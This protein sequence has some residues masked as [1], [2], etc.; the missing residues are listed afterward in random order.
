M[1]QIEAGYEPERLGRYFGKY[2]GTV[3]DNQDP[4][5]IGRIRASVPGLLGDDVECGWA[6]P[7]LPYAGPGVGSFL[8]PPVGSGVW[9]EFEAGDLDSPIWSGCWWAESEAPGDGSGE[10]ATPEIKLIRSGS[11]LILS[12]NDGESSAFLGDEGGYNALKIEATGKKSTLSAGGSVVIQAPQIELVKDA[13]HALV[14]GD[15]LMQFL[16][17]IVLAFNS[18]IHIGQM[19]ASIPVTPMAPSA[20]MTPPKPTMLS[21][22]VKTG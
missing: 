12:L 9:I 13:S 6:W 21:K 22:K 10:K 11:G 16:N 15:N 5:G 4:K 17:E 7:C 1:T 8:I 18:H 19:A 20:P 3:T 14:L 2:R